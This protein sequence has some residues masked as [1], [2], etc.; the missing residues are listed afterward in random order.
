ML[1][2]RRIA[3]GLLLA[4]TLI[5]TGCSAAADSGA[6]PADLKAKLS[7]HINREITS[8]SKTPIKGLYEVV[9]DKRE[10]I[11][12]DAKGEYIVQ[13]DLVDLAKRISLTKE[14]EAE[15][16]VTDFSKIPL[17]DGIKEIR[18]D[19]S[20]KLV[21]FSDPDCPF[22]KKLEQQSLASIDNV[23]IYTFLFPLSIHPDAE[24]KS[25]LIWC[26]DDQ[27]TAWKGF[28]FQNQLPDNK[29]ECP[30]PVAK[31]LK[32]GESLGINGTPALI[33][34][35]GRIVAGA[36]PGDVIDRLLNEAKAEAASKKK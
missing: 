2:H 15:L 34:E 3:L 12:S 26:A 27:A 29:G 5:S 9:I 28:M 18:G 7:K 19:G 21:V 35:N 16:S 22:C 10:I 8:I 11:Y 25:R 14:R 17:A 1:Q 23:T 20:R 4:G 31:N 36:V 32:L 33:F 6:P 24:R 30:N 13:G